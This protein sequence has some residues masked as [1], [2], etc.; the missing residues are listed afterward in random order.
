MVDT[1][2]VST[3]AGDCAMDCTEEEVIEEGE[4]AGNFITMSNDNI[5]VFKY[6]ACIRELFMSIIMYMSYH[7]FQ[8]DCGEND[9]E[10]VL[11]S[12]QRQL[13]QGM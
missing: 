11:Y 6:A 7:A 5:Y 10:S 3:Y 2:N 13:L 8:L 12:C 9:D 1:E 4:H